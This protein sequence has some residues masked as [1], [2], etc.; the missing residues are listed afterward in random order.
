MS[1]VP[2]RDLMLFL[3]HVATGMALADATDSER[4]AAMLGAI[5]PDLI[6]KPARILK[7]A[8]KS[9]WLAHGLP[10]MSLACAAVALT[11]PSR[12][13]RG[14]LLGY[15]SHLVCD[16]WAGGQVP[17]LAPFKRPRWKNKVPST[18]WSIFVYLLPEFVGSLVIG[19]LLS[20]DLRQQKNDAPARK[21]PVPV[22]AT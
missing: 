3:G 18:P 21:K 20:Q 10:F 12:R 14:F 9:R 11:Q 16:L 13:S 7:L 6:D 17:W 2:Y 19:A 15:A 8:H 22:D 1:F 4:E 5:L